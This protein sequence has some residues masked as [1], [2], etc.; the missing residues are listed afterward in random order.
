MCCCIWRFFSF[1]LQSTRERFFF[2]YI[3]YSFTLN[4]RSPLNNSNNNMYKATL[5][6][7]DAKYHCSKLDSPNGGNSFCLHF[8]RANYRLKNKTKLIDPHFSL[9]VSNEFINCWF[10][11]DF[12]LLQHYDFCVHS[13]L[14]WWYMV[15]KKI[16]EFFSLYH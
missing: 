14:Y 15:T 16:L 11:L 6:L 9:Y 13:L 1:F 8:I 5:L 3:F 12:S 2:T 7:F 4:L 10:F